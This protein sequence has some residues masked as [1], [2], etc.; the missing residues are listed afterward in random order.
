MFSN[1]GA[2]NLVNYVCFLLG[3]VLKSFLACFLG[4]VDSTCNSS[5]YMMN[6]T[7]IGQGR[8]DSKKVVSR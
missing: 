3:L 5:I 8:K 2:L 6:D 1:G 7:Y 4:V